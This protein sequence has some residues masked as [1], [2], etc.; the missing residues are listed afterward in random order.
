MNIIKTFNI[1]AE[2]DQMLKNAK[3]I[4]GCNETVILKNALLF[5]LR[6]ILK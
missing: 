2:L 4:L 1:T 5:Y 3:E 6:R